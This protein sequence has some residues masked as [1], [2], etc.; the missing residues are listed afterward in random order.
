MIEDVI[1]VLGERLKLSCQEKAQH[2][3]TVWEIMNSR[4]AQT[5]DFLPTGISS[6]PTD[7]NFFQR[8]LVYKSREKRFR[9]G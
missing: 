9:K 6:D 5:P 3:K 2:F 4:N 8:S 1:K 7:A